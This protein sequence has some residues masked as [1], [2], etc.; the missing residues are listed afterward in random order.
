[1]EIEELLQALL[2]GWLL[3]WAMIILSGLVRGINN[4]LERQKREKARTKELEPWTKLLQEIRSNKNDYIELTP[5][6]I[7]GLTEHYFHFFENSD[8]ILGKKIIPILNK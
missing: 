7:C 8:K 5:E 6:Q 2:A 3:G 4:K 1:M